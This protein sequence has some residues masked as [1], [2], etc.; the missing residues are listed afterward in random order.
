MRLEKF[1]DSGDI[2]PAELGSAIFFDLAEG[3]EPEDLVR[4]LTGPVGLSEEESRLNVGSQNA[5]LEETLH[6]LARGIEDGKDSRSLS[7][8]L[9]EADWPRAL[10]DAVVARTRRELGTLA[11]THDG[12][13]QLLAASRR[14]MYA[15]IAWNLVGLGVA[16][17][18][19]LGSRQGET[20]YVPGLLGIAIVL[21]PIFVGI[22]Q[23]IRGVVLWF[24]YKSVSQEASK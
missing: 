23:F 6:R 8:M 3:A 5:R 9:V 19:W 24:G 2:H 17:A 14:R 21:G 11:K 20:E 22:A 18:M 7:N 4:F 15:G 10:A 16:F 1:V 13:D 12:R